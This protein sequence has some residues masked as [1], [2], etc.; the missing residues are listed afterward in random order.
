MFSHSQ[1]GADGR[2]SIG[3]ALLRPCSAGKACREHD[4]EMKEFK[5]WSVSLDVLC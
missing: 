3:A 4:F 1:K 2:D 5:S